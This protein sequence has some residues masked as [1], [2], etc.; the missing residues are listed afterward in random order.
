MR[1]WLTDNFFAGVIFAAVFSLF[2]LASSML[3]AIYK[4][5]GTATD[6]TI[7]TE[8]APGETEFD[9]NSL[10]APAAGKSGKSAAVTYNCKDMIYQITDG[11]IKYVRE[12]GG[13]YNAAIING[14]FGLYKLVY[15][16]LQPVEIENTM[17]DPDS[18]LKLRYA[19]EQCNETYIPSGALFMAGK[20]AHF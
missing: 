3:Y 5:F 2:M 7:A 1:N 19:L 18:I 16:N 15:G 8:H 4:S 10:P 12:P 13:V 9:P 20:A 6:I 17:L 14:K 11:G